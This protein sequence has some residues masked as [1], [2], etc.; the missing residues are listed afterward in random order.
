MLKLV[1][2]TREEVAICTMIMFGFYALPKYAVQHNMCRSLDD[3]EFGFYAVLILLTYDRS[4]HVSKLKIW[5]KHADARLDEVF[6]SGP[7][8]TR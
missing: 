8:E 3:C 5:L 4:R 6:F 1:P 2:V 7:G